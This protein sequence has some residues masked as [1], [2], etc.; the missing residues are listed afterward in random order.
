V[1][2]EPRNKAQFD[3]TRL[4]DCIQNFF[5]LFSYLGDEIWRRYD[6]G[7]AYRNTVSPVAFFLPRLCS[8]AFSGIRII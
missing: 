4:Y 5:A 1:R 6:N 3:Y 2:C 7:K 8:L